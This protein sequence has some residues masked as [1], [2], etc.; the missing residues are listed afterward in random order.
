LTVLERINNTIMR[1]ETKEIAQK[2]QKQQPTE[3]PNETGGIQ[4]DE[5][6]KI[7]D[8]NTGKVLLA[9]RGDS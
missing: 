7:T 6:I 5:F 2:Q 1:S 4:V 3:Q 8:P 9:K